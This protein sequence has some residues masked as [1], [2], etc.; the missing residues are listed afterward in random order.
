MLTFEELF[1]DEPSKEGQ[2]MKQ[3]FSDAKCSR[4]IVT[5]NFY[6]SPGDTRKKGNWNWG[7]NSRTTAALLWPETWEYSSKQIKPDHAQ[8]AKAAV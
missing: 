1:V 6:T 2:K 4:C 8:A 5:G 3:R 7:G